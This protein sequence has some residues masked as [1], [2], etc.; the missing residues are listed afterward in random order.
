MA[1]IIYLEKKR[2]NN[3]DADDPKVYEEVT[4]K[5]ILLEFEKNGGGKKLYYLNFK[6][7]IGNYF[8]YSYTRDK[9]EYSELLEFLKKT[10]DGGNRIEGGKMVSDFKILVDST[11]KDTLSDNSKKIKVNPKQFYSIFEKKLAEK[12]KTAKPMDLS[13]PK[14]PMTSF[15]KSQYL[16]LKEMIL[17]I[18]IAKFT[19]GTGEGP[20]SIPKG[21]LITDI[22]S[23]LIEQKEGQEDPVKFLTD[24]GLKGEDIKSY[25]KDTLDEADVDGDGNLTKN[26]L[27]VLKEHV[28]TPLISQ[29]HDLIRVVGLLIC[30]AARLGTSRGSL[31]SFFSR[32]KGADTEFKLTHFNKRFG[33][34]LI[35]LYYLLVND[36]DKKKK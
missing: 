7:L 34:A 6:Q 23:Q 5:P 25:V 19:H 10:T 35:Y 22:Y 24:R 11:I 27:T 16:V 33:Q 15:N 20:K 29:L 1:I 12:A 18:G 4:E 32:T 8:D 3:D 2:G 31:A 30:Q 28:E 26:E 9:T 17:E 21:T 14:L 13:N 36:N